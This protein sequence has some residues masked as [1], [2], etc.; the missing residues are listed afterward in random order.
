MSSTD[1]T[2][3]QRCFELARNGNYTA[4]PNPMVGCVIVKDG[5]II[6]QGWHQMYGQAH[7]EIN[8][9]DIAGDNARDASLYV[10]MEP[11]SHL[12]KT[13]P[14]CEAVIAFGVS[15]VIFG[16]FDPNPQV[17]G[18]GVKSLEAAGIVVEGPV[19]EAE[20]L[21]INPGFVKRMKEGLPFVCCKLAMSLDGRTAMNSGES[22]W[23]TGEEARADVQKL[24]A[25]SDAVVTGVG[26][27]LADDP[28]LIVR[29]ED[30]SISQPLRVIVDS[31]LRTPARAKILN[32]PGEVLIATAAGD[33]KFLAQ[34]RDEYS[35]EQIQIRSF[36]E[37]HRQVDLRKMLEYLASEKKCNE[38]LIESGASLA[39]ALLK[40]N[41]VDEVITYIAPK[42]LGNDG[43]P[44]FILPGLEKISDQISLEIIDVVMIGKDCR[45]RSRVV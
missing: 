33:E 42:L 10:S 8:A 12:G 3:M 19:L 16:M 22:K 9:L 34:R 35:S 5:D 41:L 28:S 21:A 31:R 11:C 40:A 26:T 32:L 30:D 15:K 6:A 18:R 17:R 29:L 14:C 23:I 39:G 43:R 1:F 13:G 36:S 45:M 4:R 2:Y 20:A 25:R 24:R 7:A 37:D 27:V 44:L 38:V